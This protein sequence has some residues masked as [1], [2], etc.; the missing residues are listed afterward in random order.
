[1]S[2]TGANDIGMTEPAQDSGLSVDVQFASRPPGF[3][4]ADRL[5]EWARACWNGGVAS[6]SLL[7]TGEAE[8]RRLNAEY[9]GK[10]RPTN[11]LSFPCDPIPGVPERLLGDLVICAPVVAREA[12]E[13]GKPLEAHVAHMVVHGMLHLLGYDHEREADA[14]RMEA[15]EREILAGFGFPDPYEMEEAG[16]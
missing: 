14:R 10:D 9:R 11:V 7:V 12:A 6:V 13:Q 4:S 1:M 15:R 2:V 16:S 3:P 8:S 5:T